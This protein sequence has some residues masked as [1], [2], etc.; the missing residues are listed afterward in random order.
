MNFSVSQPTRIAGL[1]FTRDDFRFASYLIVPS[2][3]GVLAVAGFSIFQVVSANQQL[4]S[5]QQRLDFYTAQ[6]APIIAE[7]T[8][9]DQA[10]STVTT[11]RTH[12][13]TELAPL[14]RLV[15]LNDHLPSTIRLSSVTFSGDNLTVEGDTFKPGDLIAAEQTLN[16]LKI[17]GVKTS[18]DATGA[19]TWDGSFK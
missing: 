18:Q 10:N 13:L 11:L 15:Y 4:A 6:R 3:L 17:S 12:R 2:I 1:A 9:V 5:A 7:Q 14:Q 8:A 19:F 16:T